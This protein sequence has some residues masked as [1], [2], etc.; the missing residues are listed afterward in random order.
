[1]RIDSLLA[2]RSSAPLPPKLI[3]QR[4]QVVGQPVTQLRQLDARMGGDIRLHPLE[5][6]AFD[7]RPIFID[8]LPELLGMSVGTAR[9]VVR[10]H[11]GIRHPPL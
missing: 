11:A 10:V 9:F 3:H 8:R 7:L 4:H 1:M 5:P 2:S 6:A